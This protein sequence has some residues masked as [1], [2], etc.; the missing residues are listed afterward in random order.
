[1]MK[2]AI[3]KNKKE[4]KEKLFLEIFA[5]ESKQNLTEQEQGNSKMV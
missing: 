5:Y 3:R 4:K 1:M 2:A